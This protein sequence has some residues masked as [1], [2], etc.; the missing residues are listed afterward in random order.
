MGRHVVGAF[1]VMYP[2]G[3]PRRQGLQRGAQI[4][5]HVG[6]GVFLDHQRRRGVTDKSQ[7]H[8]F[9][10]AGRTHERRR[11]AGD[12]DEALSRRLDGES[13]GSDQIGGP[14]RDR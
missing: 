14:A 12:L 1:G 7:Q 9:T 11:F 13:R 2:A 6:V 5:L 10:A 4:G 8:A 3:V